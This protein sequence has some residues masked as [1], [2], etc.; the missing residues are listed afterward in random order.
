MM[1]NKQNNNPLVCSS[2]VCNTW[3]FDVAESF[4]VSMLLKHSMSHVHYAVLNV[5]FQT[6]EMI[7]HFTCFML[8]HLRFHYVIVN[9]AGMD[10]VT[11]P[12]DQEVSKCSDELQNTLPVNLVL[13]RSSKQP[14]DSK[15]SSTHWCIDE[16]IQ[17]ELSSILQFHPEKHI[18]EFMHVKT[19]SQPLWTDTIYMLPK[20]SPN[21]SFMTLTII[22]NVIYY[23]KKKLMKECNKS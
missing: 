7:N 5:L 6:I 19:N 20:C 23:C 8:F 1:C 9:P 18:D 16:E 15:H 21:M 3:C 17:W 2:Q 22:V 12:F 13:D 14:T 4:N 11:I 10:P